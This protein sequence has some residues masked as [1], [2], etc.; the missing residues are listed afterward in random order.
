MGEEADSVA[1]SIV[2]FAN[3]LQ[4]SGLDVK[5]SVVG[6]SVSGEINGGINFTNAQALSTY[7]TVKPELTEQIRFCRT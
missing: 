4:A 6:F 1:E 5:F 3:Y 2:E 7:L